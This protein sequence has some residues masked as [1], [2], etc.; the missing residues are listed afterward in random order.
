VELPA[1]DPVDNQPPPDPEFNAVV[2][3][4]RR[5]FSD[6]TFEKAI[7][8]RDSLSLRVTHPDKPDVS[9]IVRR[10]TVGLKIDIKSVSDYKSIGKLLELVDTGGTLDLSESTIDYIRFDLELATME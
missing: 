7:R 1:A 3:I 6:Y 5:H 8:A 9:I 10:T 4:L 2:E